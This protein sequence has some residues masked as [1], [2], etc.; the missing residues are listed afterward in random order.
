VTTF[1]SDENGAIQ[2][3]YVYYE[4]NK[5]TT[6]RLYDFVPSRTGKIRFSWQDKYGTGKLEISFSDEFQQF[7]GIWGIGQNLTRTYYWNGRLV[8]GTGGSDQDGSSQAQDQPSSNSPALIATGTGFVVSKAGRIVTNQHVVDG[9]SELR[10]PL[11]SKLRVVASDEQNDLALLQAPS[12]FNALATFGEARDVRPGDDVVTAGYPLQG[13]LTSDLII[14]TGIVSALAGPGND[15][16]LFQ[17]TAPVQPGNSGGPLFDGSGNVIGVIVGKLDALKVAGT[18]GS[19]PEN[20]NF[21]IG[22]W[23]VLAFLDAHN[24]PYE[25]MPN[26]RKP[27]TRQIADRAREI[28]IL[29]ECWK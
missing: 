7:S 22:T 8:A 25:T 6:G 9:C 1:Y 14:S 10:T 26:N 5:E 28:T 27:T 11:N 15:R 16:R 29:I 20:V 19:I 13:L 18:M 2:G 24:V 23:T 4:N 3:N 21:A 12:G 17:I